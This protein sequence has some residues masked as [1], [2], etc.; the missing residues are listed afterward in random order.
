MKVAFSYFLLKVPATFTEG[1]TKKLINRI[2][3]TSYSSFSLQMYKMF[4]NKGDYIWLGHIFLVT[5][6]RIRQGACSFVFSKIAAIRDFRKTRTTCSHPNRAWAR[7]ASSE[8]M[9]R[10][11]PFEY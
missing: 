5:L 6:H 8:K 9:G 4:E 3:S 2:V 1:W 11:K 7:V 10:C